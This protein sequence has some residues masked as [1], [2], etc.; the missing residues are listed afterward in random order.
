M[1]VYVIGLSSSQ[2]PFS[3]G[4]ALPGLTF[5]WT[6]TKRDILELQ[7]RHAEVGSTFSSRVFLLDEWRRAAE[8]TFGVHKHHRF[9]LNPQEAM[10]G[11]MGNYYNYTGMIT[12]IDES[13]KTSLF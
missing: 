6:T 8:I 7:S 2:T 10:N 1:P 12:I 5:H 9:Q 11:I 13:D 3:F 4:N